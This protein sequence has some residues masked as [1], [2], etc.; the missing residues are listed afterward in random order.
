MTGPAPPDEAEP[1]EAGPAAPG[2]L[3]PDEAEP[4]ASAAPDGLALEVAEV[5]R[6]AVHA[7][8]DPILP[9]L[10]H[11]LDRNKAFDDLNDRLRTAERRI[12]ARQERP[13][14]AAVHRLL[15]RVRHFDFDEAVKSAIEADLVQILGDAGYRETGQVGEAYDP[16]RHEAIEGQAID[17]TAWVATVYTRGLSCFDDVIFRAKVQV[18]PDSSTRTWPDVPG[19][20]KSRDRRG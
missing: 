16:A 4:A 14:V 15:D 5:V 11:A 8:F 3:A 9:H 1:D 17:G 10:V 20:R 19:W 13:L 18:A 2:G 7:E 6:A 12:A